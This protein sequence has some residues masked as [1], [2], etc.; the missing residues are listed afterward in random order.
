MNQG[1]QF[2]ISSVEHPP[3]SIKYPV[4]GIEYRFSSGNDLSFISILW[5]ETQLQ[6]ILHSGILQLQ[7]SGSLFFLFK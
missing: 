3:T 2:S 7:F 5:S 6:R 4:S 1:N